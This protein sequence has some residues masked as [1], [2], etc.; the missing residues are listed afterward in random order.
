MKSFFLDDS[1]NVVKKF[2]QR[3]KDNPK[4]IAILDR[5][6]KISYETLNEKANQIAQYLRKSHVKP[7]DFVGILLNPGADFIIN[8]LAIIKVGAAYLPLDTL[9]SAK[10][11]DNIIEDAQPKI[12]ITNRFFSASINNKRLIRKMKHI[13]IESAS[14]SRKN[15]F[16]KIEPNSPIYMMYTSGSTGKPRGVVISHQAVVN[17][18]LIDNYANVKDQEYVAQFSNLAFDGATFEIWSALLNGATLSIIQASIRPNQNDLHNY[19]KTHTIDCLFLPTGYFHQIIKSFPETLDTVQKIMF[20]GEQVNCLLLKNFLQYRKTNHIPITLINAYG[21]TEATTCTCRQVITEQSDLNDEVLM[22]IG[23]PISNVKT[24]ILDENK[25]KTSQGELYISGIN[26]ALR[27]HNSETSNKTKFIRNPFSDEAPYL[28]LYKT[29]DKVRQLSTGELLCLGRLD[30]QVKIGGFRIHLNEIENKLMSYAN[31]SLAAVNVEIGGGSHKMLTAYIVPTDKSHAIHADDIRNFLAESLPSYKLPTKYVMLDALPL[32][33]VGKIDKKK[34]DQ[35]PHVDLSCYIDASTSH[36]IE[37]KIKEIWCHL[38]NRTSV[39]VHKNFFDLGANSLLITEVCSLVNQE[40][41]ADLKILDIL[42]YPTIHKLSRYLEGDIKV[43]ASKEHKDITSNDIA[44]IGMSCR[45]PK[46]DSLEEFW[47]NLCNQVDCLERFTPTNDDAAHKNHVPVR[48]TLSD[49]DYFDASFFGFNP[50]DASITDPQHRI[51]I[52]CAW[53]ALEHAGVAPQKVSEKIISVFAGMTDSTYL[54]ENLLK[55]NWFLNEHEHFQQRISSSIGMLSTQLSYRLNLK[56]RSV[57]I[58]TACSTGLIA[59]DQACQDLVLGDS[60]IAIAGAISITIPQEKGYYYK[61]GSIL[62]P[63]GLCRPFSNKANGTVFSNGVGIVILKRLQD[64]IAENDTIYAVIKGRGVN[65][66]GSDKLG[67]TAPS[68]SG[69][70]ACIL[71]ALEKSGLSAQDVRYIEAHGTATH[72]G[73]LVEFNALSGAFKTHTKQKKFCA[74][75]TVKANIGHSDVAAGMAGLIKTVLSLHHKKISPMPDFIATNPDLRFAKSAFFINQTPIVWDDSHPTYHAGISSFGVGGTN[76]HMILSEYRPPNKK[77]HHT[78]ALPPK[79]LIILSAKTEHALEK[80]T[81]A[82]LKHASQHSNSIPHYIERAAYTLQTGREDFS[83][84]RYGIGKNLEEIIESFTHNPIQYHENNTSTNVVFMFPGQGM[85]YPQMGL[86]LMAIP[87]FANIVREG[88]KIT[89]QYLSCDFLSI[90]QDPHT[91]KLSETKYAQPALFIIEYALAKLLMYYGIQ[92][93]ALIGHSLGEYVAACLAGVFSFEDGVALICQRCILMAQA[94]PGAMVAIECSIDHFEKL[95][96]SVE[97]IELAL[98]NSSHHCVASGTDAAIQNLEKYLTKHTITYQKLQVSHGFHSHLMKPIKEAF[99]DILSNMKFH[100]PNIPIISNVTG[101][102]LSAKDAIDVE[103]WYQHLRHAVRLSAGLNLL[104]QDS[105]SLFIEIGPKRSLGTFLKSVLQDTSQTMHQI[106]HTLDSNHPSSDLKQLYSVIGLAWINA[107]PIDWHRFHQPM[108]PQK[109][110]LPTYIFQKQK[111]WL[112]PDKSISSAMIRSFQ[113]A[114]THH[115]IPGSI[116]ISSDILKNHTWFIIRDDEGLADKLILFFKSHGVDPIIVT[117]G[118]EYSHDDPLHFKINPNEKNHYFE[119]IKTVKQTFYYPIFL[120]LASY[121]ITIDA[122]QSIES[123][124]EKLKHGFYSLLYLS[125]ALLE[126]SN[127]P[128]QTKITV[129]TSGTQQ[130]IGTESINPINATLLGACRVITQEHPQIRLKL[131]DLN[132]TETLH[133]NLVH[134]IID[135]CI[136]QDS[137]ESSLLE[138]YRNGYQWHL[139][140]HDNLPSKNKIHRLQNNGIYLFTG[141][142]GGIALT[143]CEAIAESVSNPIFILLS[144]S[145]V[146][147]ETEWAPILQDRSN[148]YHNKIKH[149]HKLKTLGATLHIEQVDITELDPLKMVVA[150]CITNYGK[151][152]GLIHAAGISDPELMQA[153]TAA[154]IKRVFAP[155]IPGTFNLIKAFESISLDFVVL[156][157]SLGVLLGGFEQIDYCAANACLDAIAISGFFSHAA[158][159]VSINWNTWRDVGMANKNRNEGKINFIDQGNDVSPIEGKKIFLNVLQTENNQIAISKIDINEVQPVSADINAYMPKISREQ[160]SITTKYIKPRNEVETQLL[161]L[162]QETLGIN[163]LSVA[164]NF[165]ALGGHSLQALN[166]IKKINHTFHCTL[167]MTQIYHSATIEELSPLISDK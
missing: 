75:G 25:N 110:N 33:T 113:P 55:N 35:I 38:L 93:N 92:P 52:E 31:I 117:F 14:Y 122:T 15:F 49:I 46:A 78:N 87:Y 8:M 29:G 100:A 2:E 57:N 166:L 120:N 13:S 81:D 51:F 34:L 140:Y 17:L 159:V 50:V 56:G 86:E 30:D 63:D 66:D 41:H 70:M 126:T 6:L 69:Q 112:D 90:L 127:D 64:A 157:S 161:Q 135:S 54:Q 165:F 16:H 58:N 109:L 115:K 151:I 20:G 39:D 40:L 158:F 91:K 152:N 36:P 129:I 18:T 118:T 68:H 150:R 26:L 89:S 97:G 132:P 131:I 11:L 124:E 160:L 12:I 32:T 27:Y 82:F 85:Q 71:N 9:I 61:E 138:S 119:F 3:A 23:K 130:I 133:Q 154:S 65:N 22:S 136:N 147:P 42:S 103:Y 7:G 99:I 72:L 48:G 59:V 1:L 60:D 156:K 101:D 162:W 142:L 143:C 155:K 24:Y 105:H 145:T 83:Y 121:G 62:S 44:I 76:T 37:K 114:W 10:H 102:W 95:Q 163:E 146:P 94:P 134:K 123:I 79:Q 5:S 104:A 153:K 4:H 128:T 137:E 77:N 106:V 167:P 45:F 96:S 116:T 144:R 107:I 148:P 84:R 111:Y 67:Y 21:P 125:Q 98:H 47:M 73:D 43:R 74:L 80:M 53:E 88:A 19:L 164:D 139:M 28:Y 149:L 141:G 108:Q